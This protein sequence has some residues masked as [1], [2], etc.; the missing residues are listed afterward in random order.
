MCI[1]DSIIEA[2]QRLR[3]GVIGKVL[4]CRTFYASRR[5]S[6]GKGKPAPVP[7]YLNYDLWQGPAPERPY[8]DNLIRTTGIGIG[9]T[10]GAKWPT[11]AFTRSI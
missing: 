6:I 11:T 10:A 3:E 5:G 4:S 7:K 1:R 2:M 9:T 8:K